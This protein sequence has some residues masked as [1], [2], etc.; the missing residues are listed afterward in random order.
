MPT[1]TIRGL[2]ESVKV[3]LEARA[4]A[5]GRSMEAEARVLIADAVA[6]PVGREDLGTA[7]HRRFRDLGGVELGIDRS[8]DSA[9]GVDFGE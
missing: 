3:A 5:H 6:A 4:R 9:R 8:R 1:L 2:D 7:I